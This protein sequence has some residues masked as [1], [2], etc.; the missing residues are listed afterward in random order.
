MALYI[1]NNQLSAI[2]WTVP[3]GQGE[4]DKMLEQ[5]RKVLEWYDGFEKYVPSWYIRKKIILD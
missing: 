1:G 3:F 4:V 2:P 5:E